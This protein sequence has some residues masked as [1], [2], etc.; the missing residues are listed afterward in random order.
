MGFSGRK[1]PHSSLTDLNLPQN[2]LYKYPHIHV[3]VGGW[4]SGLAL[5]ENIV[6]FPGAGDTRA[7]KSSPLGLSIKGRNA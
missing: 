7:R 5:L 2:L 3:N 6:E 1:R 4:G